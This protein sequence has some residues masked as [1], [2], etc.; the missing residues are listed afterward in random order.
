MTKQ[1]ELTLRDLKALRSVLDL[2]LFD[3]DFLH[4]NFV[5]TLRKA[6]W[7]DLQQK[8]NEWIKEEQNEIAA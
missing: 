7:R 2:A 8:I 5:G 6:H 4:N 1:F 3:N